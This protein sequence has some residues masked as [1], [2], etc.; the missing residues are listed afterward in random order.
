MQVR[1]LQVSRTGGPEHVRGTVFAD[2]IHQFMSTGRPIGTCSPQSG[3]ITNH[4][5]NNVLVIFR[6]HRTDVCSS[7][8]SSIAAV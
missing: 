6:Q 2:K 4:L 1:P 8:L 5:I 7:E 3:T